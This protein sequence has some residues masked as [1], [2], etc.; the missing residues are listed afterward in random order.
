MMLNIPKFSLKPETMTHELIGKISGAIVLLSGIIY[1][2]QII[3]RR[4]HP[5]FASW[6]IWAL[7]GGAVWINYKTSG[8]TDNAWVAFFGMI[9]PVVIAI[10]AFFYEK[11]VW[12]DRTEVI[13]LMLGLISIT[14]WWFMEKRGAEIALY[15]AIFADLCAAFPT[16]RLFRKEPWQDRPL[17]WILFALG[18]GLA[19]FA[20]PDDGQNLAN[21][22]LPVYMVTMSSVLAWFLVRYRIKNKDP[23]SEWY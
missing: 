12:P 14:I 6:C 15:V 8:A 13:C 19:M 4:V 23:F 10:L 3:Q 1:M 5:N 11:R 9:N 22:A 18:F 21:Y 2:R 16:A 17:M 7:I 20:I